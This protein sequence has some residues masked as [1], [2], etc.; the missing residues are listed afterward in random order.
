MIRVSWLP[1]SL[2]TPINEDEDES[3]LGNFIEDQVTPTPN[4]SVYT[5]LLSEKIDEILDSLPYREA[6]ILRLRFGL[7]TAVSTH[8]KKWARSSD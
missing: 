5:K 7:K 1:L 6:R 4:Q 2:E 3:E 8:W